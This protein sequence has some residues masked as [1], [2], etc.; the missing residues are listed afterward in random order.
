[1]LLV[2]KLEI[3]KNCKEVE[4]IMIMIIAIIYIFLSNVIFDYFQK[5]LSPR[6]PPEKIVKIQKVQVP[7]FC[8]HWKLEKSPPSPCGKCLVVGIY[9]PSPRTVGGII[10]VI[11][12]RITV[13]IYDFY[14]Q[15]IVAVM[16]A[17][18]IEFDRTK[19]SFSSISKNYLNLKK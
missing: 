9:F 3:F 7:P 12:R 6:P 11:Y 5:I 19:W 13:V 4:H 18:V 10:A 15:Y 1:M 8:Q 2:Y 14:S 17:A 16:I